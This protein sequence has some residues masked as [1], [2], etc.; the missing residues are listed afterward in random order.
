MR[1]NPRV[2]FSFIDYSAHQ[3]ARGL[4]WEGWISAKRQEQT[5]HLESKGGGRCCSVLFGIPNHPSRFLVYAASSYEN[6]KAHKAA[7]EESSSANPDREKPTISSRSLPMP[8]RRPKVCPRCHHILPH[9]SLTKY[10][11]LRLNNKKHRHHIHLHFDST[12]P[13]HSQLRRRRAVGR[14]RIAEMANWHF[15]TPPR[16]RRRSRRYSS[17]LAFRSNQYPMDY[18]VQKYLERVPLNQINTGSARPE[19]IYRP[20]A[21]G[22]SES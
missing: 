20:S 8:R 13:N 5:K 4:I 11:L 21:P 10:F 19:Y 12:P 14:V 18:E 6:K 17:F 3:V 7:G 16:V 2:R 22:R 15:P 9:H 1:S